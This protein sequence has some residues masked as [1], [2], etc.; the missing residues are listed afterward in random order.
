MFYRKNAVFALF[1]SSL[2]YL[3]IFIVTNICINKSR[4]KLHSKPFNYKNL[5][6]KEISVNDYDDEDDNGK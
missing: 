2:I 5:K 6:Q 1:M 4:V 3:V